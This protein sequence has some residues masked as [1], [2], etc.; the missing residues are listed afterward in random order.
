MSSG[1]GSGRAVGRERSLGRC[2]PSPGSGES[3]EGSCE[4]FIGSCETSPGTC[5]SSRGSR[6]PSDGRRELVRRS[7]AR[8]TRALRSTA[9]SDTLESAGPTDRCGKS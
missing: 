8:A 3:S 9:A 7:M 4:S 5:D 1:E 2:E 6:E